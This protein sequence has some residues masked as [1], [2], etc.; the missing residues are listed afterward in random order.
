MRTYDSPSVRELV[1]STLR[2]Y[3]TDTMRERG[4]D[5][6]ILDVD[7]AILSMQEKKGGATGGV[8]R[9]RLPVKTGWSGLEHPRKFGYT[10]SHKGRGAP[11]YK[12]ILGVRSGP[13]LS[14]RGTVRRSVRGRWVAA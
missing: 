5:I 13:A 8:R 2:S 3:G 4:V 7:M 1:A 14:C 10:R 11:C 6:P 12:P 9:G